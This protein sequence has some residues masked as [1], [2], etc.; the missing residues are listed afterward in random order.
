MRQLTP[1]RQ[2]LCLALC[3]AACAASPR[4]A[5]A[6]A[7]PGAL[8]EDSVQSHALEGNLL[9][10]SARRP[11]QIYLPPGYREH[12][13]RRYP[14]VFLLHG[15]L[16]SYK[17]WTEGGEG[18]NIANVLDKLIASDKTRE[19]IVVMPDARNRLGG[20]FYTNSVATGNWE[21]YLCRELVG[22]VDGHYRTLARP[23]SRGIAGHSMGGYG[24]ILLAM[25]HPETFGAVYAQSPA[26]L[27]W[28]G[29][30]SRDNPAWEAT[31]SFRTLADFDRASESDYIAKAFVAMAAAWSPDPGKPPFYGDYPVSG[32]GPDRKWQEGARARWSANMPVYLADQYRSGLARLRAIAF[33]VG[34]RDQF[35]HIPVTCRAFASALKRNRIP[36]TFE[37][38]DGD[39]N[40]QVPAR[41]VT[42]VLPFFS[43]ALAGETPPRP[44]R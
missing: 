2:P 23:E 10:D 11:V 35:S 31:F 9:G 42:K 40:D 24:A 8:V 14:V 25:K 1:F 20:S 34:S 3:L 33:D 12:P 15:Y 6:D 39:H 41:I 18:W 32:R 22:H 19:M 27:G 16:G 29:D 30:L 43:R 7:R 37:E 21:D 13:E 26:V 36:Y 17:Q 44:P 4:P 28:G 38:Y 5:Q